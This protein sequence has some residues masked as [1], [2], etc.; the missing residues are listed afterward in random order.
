MSTSN[1]PADNIRGAIILT[2]G[3]AAFI[4][5]V[6]AAAKTLGH[7]GMGALQIAWSRFT[8]SAATR[9]HT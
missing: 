8:M 4:P 9:S 5:L 7:E 6:D 1:A 2:L 3:F